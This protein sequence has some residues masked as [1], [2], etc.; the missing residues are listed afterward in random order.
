MNTP[1]N[2]KELDDLLTPFSLLTP[3][4]ED[5]L[6]PDDLRVVEDPAKGLDALVPDNLR[7]AP[8]DPNLEADPSGLTPDVYR[9]K[10]ED[11][12]LGYPGDVGELPV[13]AKVKTPTEETPMEMSSRLLKEC[14]EELPKLIKAKEDLLDRQEKMI[15]EDNAD[16]RAAFERV[17]AK[18]ELEGN[19]LVLHFR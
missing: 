6:V 7:V 12:P 19:P 9:V 4:D 2:Q 17:I 15:E 16:T 1:A 3:D 13:P 10:I 5:P 8:D 14:G 11:D 18:R